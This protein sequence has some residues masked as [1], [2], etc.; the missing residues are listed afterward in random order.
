M[1]ESSPLPSQSFHLSGE[2]AVMSTTISP[3]SSPRLLVAQARYAISPC[4]PT[5]GPQT[6]SLSS[7][8]LLN[9]S[10]RPLL[11][12][13]LAPVMQP[14][15]LGSLVGSFGPLHNLHFNS[16]PHRKVLHTAAVVAVHVKLSQQ[17]VIHI[18]RWVINKSRAEG[19]HHYWGRKWK[20]WENWREVFRTKLH[21][22]D[23]QCLRQKSQE[24]EASS[25]FVLLPQRFST[26]T[27]FQTLTY[28]TISQ[29]NYHL[30]L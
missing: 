17:K 27:L 9:Y 21:V 4:C 11:L 22:G 3:G 16:L 7:G 18:Q 20:R 25:A 2:K 5:G 19:V 28:E 29:W 24:A 30:W 14:A 26:F 15:R 13:K 1:T 12:T 8:L 10:R 6:L 23:N